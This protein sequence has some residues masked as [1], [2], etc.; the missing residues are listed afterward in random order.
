M[1]TNPA[2][3]VREPV[4]ADAEGIA[5]VH[6]DAWR[7]TYSGQLP[8]QF[9]DDD[10]FAARKQFWSRLLSVEPRPARVAVA[11]LDGEIVG[12]AM[13][14][15]AKGPDAEKGF[16]AARPLHLFSI[17]LLARQHGTGAGQALLDVVLKKDPAQL[18]VAKG[19]ERALAF[20]TRNGFEPDGVEY[21]DPRFAGFV[22]V[23]LVR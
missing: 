22:E 7:E 18:W 15:D 14:G 21:S 8:E 9:F 3:V 23:R 1:T 12:F 2:P 20:Y 19:N 16:P 4:A 5:R 17:Y 6:V 10:A 11:D 13:A